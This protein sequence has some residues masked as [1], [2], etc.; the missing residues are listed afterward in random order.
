MG[1]TEQGNIVHDGRRPFDMEITRLDPEEIE[2]FVDE[3]W[4]AAQ[5]EMAS[6]SEYSLA[7]SIREDGLAYQRS[8]STDEKTTTFLARDDGTPIGYVAGEV[9]TP[10]P[11]FEQVRECYISELYV[12]ETERRRGVA[13]ALL[14]RIETWAIEQDCTG[15]DLSVHVANT[16]AKSLYETNGYETYRANMQKE[17]EVNG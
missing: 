12:T 15:M 4:L 7:D 3:I 16:P 2:S 6:I 14:N 5:R 1:P 9:Q 10:P 11:I 13:T 8:R 17:L